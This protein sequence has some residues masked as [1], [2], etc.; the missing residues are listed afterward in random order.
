MSNNRVTEAAK[1]IGKGIYEAL[2]EEFAFA[3][4]DI[5]HKVVEQP[6]FGRPVTP[7][8]LDFHRWLTPEK[9]EAGIH[10]KQEPVPEQVAE[11]V[12]EAPVI[13]PVEGRPS[14]LDERLAEAEAYA[15]HQQAGSTA[16]MDAAHAYEWRDFE[17]IPEPARNEPEKGSEQ[18]QELE[19]WL[20]RQEEHKSRETDYKQD[21]PEKQQADKDA[22]EMEFI[23]DELGR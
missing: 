5:R 3:L 15:R 21:S 16:E 6:W 18:W 19:A 9:D 12:A 23:D 4:D 22:R 8:A 11:R 17:P 13:E 7:E 10:G 1:S 14:N 2:G 20:D